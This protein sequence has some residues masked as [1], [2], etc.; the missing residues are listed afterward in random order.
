MKNIT[1]DG[2][3]L[4]LFPNFLKPYVPYVWASLCHCVIVSWIH[5]GS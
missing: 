3:M 1:E 2:N 4:M 5:T